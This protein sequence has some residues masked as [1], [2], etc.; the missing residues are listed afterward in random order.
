MSSVYTRRIISST[1]GAG[2]QATVVVPT[3]RVWIIRNVVAVP[4]GASSQVVGAIYAPYPVPIA[5][6]VQ[7]P[8]TQLVLTEDT[9]IVVLAGETI[10]ALAVTGNWHFTVT[11]YD[12]AA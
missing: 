5:V 8:N 6:A 12:F 1:Q 3:G 9:R 7:A 2:T 4:D 10:A 11:G